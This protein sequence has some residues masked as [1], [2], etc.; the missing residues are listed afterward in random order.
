M[1]KHCF[2]LVL[3]LLSVDLSAQCEIAFDEIDEFDSLRTVASSS[4]AFGYMVPSLYETVS[5]PRLIEEGKAIVMYSE[6]DTINSF[7]LTLAIPEY[8]FQPIEAG[9]NVRMKLSDGEVISFYNV[10]DRGTFDDTTNM[11]L[12]QHTII[13]PLDMFYRLTFST[14]EAIRIEYK[15]LKRTF[16]LNEEQQDAIR[17]AMQCVGRQVELY[18]VKP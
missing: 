15:K 6:N 2:W 11:R 5:G 3:L 7:F 16:K 10:P 8:T 14:I 17:D 13:V 4:V 18:P 12:Y 1:I 9:F